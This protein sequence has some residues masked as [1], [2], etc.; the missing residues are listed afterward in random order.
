M[1]KLLY[2]FV[3]LLILSCDNDAALEKEISKIPVETTIYRFDQEFAS[4][5]VE[6]LPGLKNKY[7]YLFPE[8]YHDSI[9]VNR[10]QDTLQQELLS[11]TN[12]QFSSFDAYATQL[13]SLFQHVKYYNPS[14][15]VPTVVTVT[16]DVDY[17]YKV[18]YNNDIMLLSLDT[19][20]GEDH[21]FYEGIQ[22]YIKQDMNPRY[23]IPDC[24]LAIA[25]SEILNPQENTF[26]SVMLWY[27]KQ[28]YLS[29]KYA[30]EY[31]EYDFLHFTEAEM[32]WANENEEQIW[33]YFIENELLYSNNP[34]VLERFVLP[35]PFSKFYLQ[36]DNESP[37]QLGLFIGFKIV[38]AYMKNNDVS[39][40]QLMNTS[41][42]EIFK[43]AAYKPKK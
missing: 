7:P 18:L 21:M 40:Q 23:I 19:Y 15:V 39:L 31:K 32:I 34:K 37:G 20:L 41:A 38:D 4:A 26:L 36:L 24:A 22:T 9:W 43:N 42:T 11:E 25:K 10:M 35:A 17:K 3:F 2:L 29:K 12:K 1:N 27:G 33:K 30:P 16:S 28:I 5:N 14:F 6:T 13:N 8:D